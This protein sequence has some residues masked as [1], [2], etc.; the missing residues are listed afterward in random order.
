VKEAV[1]QTNGLFEREP[2][3]RLFFRGKSWQN[4]A[5]FC[6]KL[7][8]NGRKSWFFATDFIKSSQVI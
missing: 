5:F 2:V 3:L 6:H 1:L 4:L 7:P 8:E